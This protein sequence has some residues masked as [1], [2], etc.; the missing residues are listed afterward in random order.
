M[1]RV[2]DNAVSPVVGVMLMLVVTLVLAA[3]VSAFVGGIGG[4]MEG[5]PST[6]LEVHI[7]ANKHFSGGTGADKYEFYSS[8]M[9]IESLSGDTISTKDLYIVT[10]FITEGT[11]LTGRLS[12]EEYVSGSAGWTDFSDST[13]CGVLFFSDPNRYPNVLTS[14]IGN[15]AWFGNRSAV[16]RPGDILATPAKYSYTKGEEKS[17]SET[18][19]NEA[20]E[21]IFGLSDGLSGDNK[22]YYA[23][24]D[25]F[26]G[27]RVDVKILH[28]PSGKCIYDREVVIE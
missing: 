26:A 15:S 18:E 21:K 28:Y 27:N 1:P 20:I 19:M 25:F 17:P 4:D 22:G 9:S 13:N 2:N 8:D 5:A 23:N 7:Y 24:Q 6:I 3:V 10:Y 16:L 14:E 12:G 11:T